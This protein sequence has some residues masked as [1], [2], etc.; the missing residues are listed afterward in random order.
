M[1]AG[2]VGGGSGGT[3]E[4]EFAKGVGGY[5][6]SRNYKFTVVNSENVWAKAMSRVLVDKLTAEQAV[7]EMIA[8]IKDIAG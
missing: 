7:D 2:S 8:R 1:V 3:S 5:E 6:M 4:V